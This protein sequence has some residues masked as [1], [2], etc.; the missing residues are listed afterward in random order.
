L[1]LAASLDFS[2]LDTSNDSANPAPASADLALVN[3]GSGRDRAFS[4]ECFA[5]GI[6]ADEPLPPLADQVSSEQRGVHSEQH[7]ERPSFLRQRGDSIIFDPSSFQEG[8]ILEERALTSR[9]RGLSVDL[10]GIISSVPSQPNP[11]PAVERPSVG[12]AAHGSRGPDGAQGTAQPPA[13]ANVARRA[14]TRLEPGRPQPP[15]QIRHPGQP[16]PAANARLA[17]GALPQP[18]HATSAMPT[19]MATSNGHNHIANHAPTG[20]IANNDVHPTTTT[21][22]ANGTV[23]VVASASSTTLQLELLNKDGRI[24]IYLPEARKERIARFHAKR[25]MRIWRKRIKYDCRKKLADSRPR[26]KGRFVK[27][28]D[29]DD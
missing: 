26:I 22:T 6:N 16:N 7:Q 27:R 23:A 8:G 1:L 24:G 14:S 20:M 25:K 11:P 28:T 13:S 5:F 12:N 4:F 18:Q 9:D 21:I 2:V 29:M 19:T 15:S 3:G 10:D 17:V